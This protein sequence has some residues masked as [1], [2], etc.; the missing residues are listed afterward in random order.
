MT[1]N[2]HAME[3]EE[4]GGVPFSHS[5]VRGVHA[6]KRA[7]T[8]LFGY[9]SADSF[10]CLEFSLIYDITKTS[11]RCKAYN[12]ECWEHLLLKLPPGYVWSGRCGKSEMQQLIINILYV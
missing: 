10:V 7:V 12:I 4:K 11:Y 9:S 8:K 3:Q 5:L 2:N 1:T 6:K